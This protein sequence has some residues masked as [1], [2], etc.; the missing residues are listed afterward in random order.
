MYRARHRRR[1]V[2]RF[3]G[4]LF[5]LGMMGAW[6]GLVVLLGAIAFMREGL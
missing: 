1:P 4:G 2:R 3:G 6:L 5:F